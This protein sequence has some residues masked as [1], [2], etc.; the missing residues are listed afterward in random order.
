MIVNGT[1]IFTWQY[2]LQILYGCVGTG[3]DVGTL[4]RTKDLLDGHSNAEIG[5][6]GAQDAPRV[7]VNS[8]KQEKEDDNLYA[9]GTFPLN[10]V[11]GKYFASCL[12]LLVELM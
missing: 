2:R 10:I 11:F 12:I 3:C 5:L 4:K 9:A 1:F 6:E 8:V 7:H